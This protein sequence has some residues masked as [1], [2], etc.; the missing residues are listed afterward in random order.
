MPFW[1]KEFMAK[2]AI[3][4]TFANFLGFKGEADDQESFGP[5]VDFHRL[6][7]IQIVMSAVTFLK[8]KLL[9]FLI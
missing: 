7:T 6:K 9:P 4:I 5:I 3:W 2:L 1:F 8:K